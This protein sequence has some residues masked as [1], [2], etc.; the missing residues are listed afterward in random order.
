VF[1]ALKISAS[2]FLFRILVGGSF[3]VQT[4]FSLEEHLQAEKATVAA[5]PFTLIGRLVLHDLG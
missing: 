5:K 2:I 3:W 1:N 4:N